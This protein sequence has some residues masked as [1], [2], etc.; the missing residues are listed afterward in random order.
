M[1]MVEISP[2]DIENLPPINEKELY[3]LLH[4]VGEGIKKVNLKKGLS[5]KN[6]IKISTKK[7][8]DFYQFRVNL[9]YVIYNLIS[10]PEREK[11]EL[12]R[13]SLITIIDLPKSMER[14]FSD[15]LKKGSSLISESRFSAGFQ[16]NSP[17][18]YRA[19]GEGE[20]KFNIKNKELITTIITKQFLIPLFDKVSEIKK[21]ELRSYL[22]FFFKEFNFVSLGFINYFYPENA[23]KELEILKNSF[24]FFCSNEFLNQASIEL[25]QLSSWIH[26][27]D[28]QNDLFN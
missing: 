15:N 7:G 2:A 25:L 10:K 6:V 17:K 23:P 9:T 14:Q 24:D 16:D 28:S 26:Q 4:K 1:K 21:K 27:I 18:A 5:E 12:T 11:I 22:E 8:H 19:L 3:S 13:K 20:M